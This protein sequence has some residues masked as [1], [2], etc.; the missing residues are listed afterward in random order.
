LFLGA[1][2][3]NNVA[4]YTTA[5][6]AVKTTLFLTGQGNPNP[7]GMAVAGGDLFMVNQAGV[8][9]Y[10]TNGTTVNNDL[11]DLGLAPPGSPPGIPDPFGIAVEIPT[12]VP[13][14]ATYSALAGISILGLVLLRNRGRRPAG[15]LPQS[16]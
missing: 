6:T 14:P 10:T 8:G 5:G 13:E 4:E 3:S 12:A 2:I 9:E 16:S 1:H 7:G 11:I 15:K